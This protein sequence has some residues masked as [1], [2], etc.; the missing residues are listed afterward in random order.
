MPRSPVIRGRPLPRPGPG[1]GSGYLGLFPSLEAV[2]AALHRRGELLEVDLERVQDVVGVVLRAEADLTLPRPCVLDDLVGLTL[3]LLHDLLVG[4]QPRLLLA[5]L[6][7]DPL[8]LALRLRE[9][10]LP[11]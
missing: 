7:D 11:L 9:H 4:D 10:L 8:G 2:A 6:L 5:R 1:A 3:R